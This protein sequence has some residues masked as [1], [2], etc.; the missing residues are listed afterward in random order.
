M[1]NCYNFK[2][3]ISKYLDD[4][5][6]YNEKK[7]FEDHREECQECRQLFEGIK[8]TKSQLKEL[9]PPELSPD[10][11]PNLRKKIIQLRD[12]QDSTGILTNFFSK[13][14]VLSYGFAAALILAITVFSVQQYRKMSPTSPASSSSLLK[15]RMNTNIKPPQQQFSSNQSATVSQDTALDSNSDSINKD[16]LEKFKKNITPVKGQ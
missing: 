5:I 13:T 12:D 9:Q 10:F 8:V 14:P 16:N 4:E 6:S 1:Q 11:M 15:E 3:L 7:F 2:N